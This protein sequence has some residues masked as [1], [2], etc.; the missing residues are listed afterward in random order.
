MRKPKP[1]NIPDEHI[2]KVPRFKEE[3]GFYASAKSS[4]LM[5]RILAKNNKADVMLRKALWHHGYR[6][7]AYSKKLVGNPDIIFPKYRIAIFVDGD[8]WH[9]YDWEQKK[10]KISTNKNYW[11]PKIER[12]MQ[13]DLEVTQTLISQG[14]RVIRFWEHEVKK[15][16]EGCVGEALVALKSIV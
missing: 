7:R 2:I 13:R 15:S 16:F 4:A 14:W 12:N 3:A 9:G 5:S 6:Y 10:K 8:F 1:Y 11:I